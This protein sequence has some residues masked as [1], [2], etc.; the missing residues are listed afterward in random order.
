MG[1][2]VLGD[3]VY[4]ASPPG[5]PL[6]LHARSIE[7]PLYYPKRPPVVATAPVPAHMAEALRMCGFQEG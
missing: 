1:C 5:V 6:H 7:V 2:P 4:G 3:P